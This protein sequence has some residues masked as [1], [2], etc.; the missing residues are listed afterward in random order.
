[1]ADYI[2]K[3]H[4]E[5]GIFCR[6]K[7]LI[8]VEGNVL[9]VYQYPEEGSISKGSILRLPE[10]L[11][12]Y[13]KDQGYKTI[14]FFDSMQ[15]FY[16]SC[17]DGHIESFAE[18]T[19]ARVDGQ[20][21]RSEFKGKNNSA[22][23]IVRTAVSQNKE[24]VVIVMNLAS[25]YIT[26]PDNVDQSEVDSFTNLLLA[27]MEGKDVRTENGML[28]NL[29]VMIVNKVNDV[30]A[31]FY[32]DNPNVK[33]INIG[34]PSKEEREAL[35]KGENFETFFAGDIFDEDYPYYEEHPDELDKVQDK[36]V[37][38]TEGFSFTEIN[39]LRR[40]CK[41]ERT[42]I[43]QM[44]SVVDL[45]R[46]GIKEN[47]WDSLDVNELKTAKEDFQK[48][49]KGQDF[50]IVKTLDVVKR[51][52]TG[53]AGLNSSSHGKPKGILF[54]AGP[55]GTGK[56][57]TAKTLAE[58]L[59]GDESCCIRFDMSEY[60]QSH[61]DQ[62]LLG[63]PP[64]YVGYEAGGQLTNAVKENPFSIL[65]FD[66]IEKAHPSIFDKFLQILEDG[67]MT[68]GQ[69][70]TV[71]FSECIIIFTSNLGIYTRNEFGAREPNVTPD[72]EYPEVQR[73]VRQAIEDY[74]KLELGRPEILN[75]IGENIVVFDFIRPDVAKLIL[76]A[77]VN[78]IIK[79]LMT[80]KTIELVP[81]EKAMSILLSKAVD[82]LANG[83]RGIGNIVESLLI[84]PLAR[85]MFDEEIR[86]KVK[87]T[88]EDIDAENM[89]YALSCTCEEL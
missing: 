65:L 24:P 1:M 8:I 35:I 81:S 64:G 47:P 10:Y 73:K 11:H 89:P 74:F 44:S 66:E 86:E 2:A 56:T 14:V 17:E 78:K 69:G 45:Y 21:I 67:R 31:W 80:E 72:M 43:R 48:R 82:N 29:V 13:F 83:G 57:E 39:G 25:R 40:L 28:K 26:S 38:L 37:G 79:N 59:F 61:S 60:S 19:K 42:R 71:Y 49:V 36:F 15:G 54:F 20:F 27:S 84:N 33:T 3:W 62:K 9:D 63:A 75:R 46:Y 68:D 77:Q 4:K 30:P 22:T 76:D 41:N 88:I 50:A 12:Y 85:Y 5:L 7:P 34:T 87:I 23:S 58:K 16:N 6:I 70:N 55:T 51:A 18:I 52:V 53:M 32:L